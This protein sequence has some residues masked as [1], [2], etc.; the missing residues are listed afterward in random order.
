MSRKEAIEK[1]SEQKRDTKNEGSL[2]RM[3]YQLL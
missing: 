2:K 1:E 3:Y